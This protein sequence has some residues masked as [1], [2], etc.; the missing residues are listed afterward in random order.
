MRRRG[1]EPPPGY[2]GPG[3][4]PGHP[5]VR[6]VQ[7]A[8]ERPDRRLA[9][10]ERTH[11]TAWMLPRM[12]PRRPRSERSPWA[13][14]ARG[15]RACQRRPVCDR[16]P[17]GGG[18]GTDVPGRSFHDDAHRAGHPAHPNAETNPDKL[19]A[20]DECAIRC[21]PH[22]LAPV[23][24]RPRRDATTRGSDAVRGAD[25]SPRRICSS[26]LSSAQPSPRC[27]ASSTERTSSLR[28]TGRNG[29]SRMPGATASVRRG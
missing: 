28:L 1:L 20:G 11:R 13:P 5:S 7:I 8:Q 26:H 23:R 10:T 15:G 25:A 27:A 19:L 16:R 12:L 22:C 14:P 21:A 9:W 17:S 4:Q 18:S 3:P 29:V 6:S 24:A 2:P